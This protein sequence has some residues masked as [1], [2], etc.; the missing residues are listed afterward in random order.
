MDACPTEPAKPF[1][2][3]DLPAELRL[4][5]YEH[6][7]TAPD[8]TIRIYYS[9]Q[10]HRTNP[11]LSLPLL[12][13][14]RQIHAEARDI[15]CQENAVFVHADVHR[16][17]HPVIGASQLPPA[18]LARLRRLFVVL[19]ILNSSQLTYDDTDFRPF[20]AMVR[21]RQLR[22][23]AVDEAGLQQH[24]DLAGVTRLLSR[25][26][27]RVPANCALDYAASTDAERAFVAPWTNAKP[28]RGLPATAEVPRDV[29]MRAAAYSQAVQGC[30]SGDE[31]DWRLDPAADPLDEV[32]TW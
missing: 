23:A 3:L 14:C 4:R 20:Q 8:K 30:K 19:D 15:L 18:A 6:A 21:L 5:I 10:E 2:L 27:E 1:R 32:R 29:L 31:G 11:T 16:L 24:R 25:L 28:F 22:I 26:I 9:Y 13:T 7:L 17:G 12:R